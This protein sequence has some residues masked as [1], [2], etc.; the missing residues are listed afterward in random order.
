MS[1]SLPSGPLNDNSPR[2][3]PHPDSDHINDDTES[4]APDS[5]LRKARKRKLLGHSTKQRR[6]V[7]SRNRLSHVENG[8]QSSGATFSTNI[9]RLSA[10]VGTGG[11]LEE[12]KDLKYLEFDHQPGRRKQR[13]VA[14]PHG[15]LSEVERQSKGIGGQQVNAVSDEKTISGNAGGNSG[16]ESFGASEL[17][18]ETA[19]GGD[20]DSPTPVHGPV[21]AGTKRPY[22]PLQVHV[23]ADNGSPKRKMLR[24]R[25]DGKLSSPKADTKTEVSKLKMKRKLNKRTA[26]PLHKIVVMK[27]GQDPTRRHLI[28]LK[29][30]NVLAKSPS[31]LYKTPAMDTTTK[32]PASLTEPP[33]PT[34]P[35]F[36]GNS[37]FS[38]RGK[39]PED[40]RVSSLGTP[41][42]A[43]D[44]LAT[45]TA[46]SRK[47]PK[48]ISEADAAAWSRLAAGFSK[49][50]TMSGALMPPWPGGAMVHCRGSLDHAE[51]D[52]SITIRERPMPSS[53][54]KLKH[55]ET[56]IPEDE[57]ILFKYR[58][59]LSQVR[60]RLHDRAHSLHEQ[61]W[62]RKPERRLM[63]GSQVQETVLNRMSSTLPVT[64]AAAHAGALESV[65]KDT[66]T[67]DQASRKPRV[68][69]ALLQVFNDIASSLSPFDR[70]EC[71]MQD[72][73]HKYAPDCAANVLQPGQEA[74][75]LRDWLGGSKVV[76]VENGIIDREN[77]DAMMA[78]RRSRGRPRKKRKRAEE[79]DGF[80]LS[81]D[82]EGNEMDEITDPEDG[83]STNLYPF[84][85]KRTIMRA[86]D[87]RS[88]SQ[89]NG[90]TSRATNAVV[91]SGPHGCG[92]TAAVYAVAQ[93]L[94][95]EV[96]EINSGSRRS[97]KDL[98]DRVGD[99]TKNHL[100]H[101][102]AD[103]DD[104]NEVDEHL[105]IV[106]QELDSGRQSS[107]Q[108][109]LKPKARSKP[110]LK[111]RAASR[112]RLKNPSHQSPKKQK[113]QKQSLILL[114][115]VDVLF[116]ED[117][118]FWAT[119]VSLILQSKRPIIMTCTD[120][121]LLPLD[122]MVLHAI[123][124]FVAPPEPLAVD[125][126]LLLAGDEGHIL[127]RDAISTL[128]IS[129]HS[130]LRASISELNFWCRMA[131]GD[132]RG[133]LDWMLLGSSR[134]DC[135]N[136]EG[137]RLRVVS[138]GTYTSGMGFLDH[139]GECESSYNGLRGDTNLLSEALRWWNIDLE[140]W[141]ALYRTPRALSVTASEASLGSL[142][143]LEKF[144]LVTDAL[145]A[146]D[147]LP[148]LGFRL[149]NDVRRQATLPR[150]LT[151]KSRW[152][153]TAHNLSL[154]RRCGTTIL[155]ALLC[156]R[157]RHHRISLA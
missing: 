143:M 111:S 134:N 128:Y 126:L 103:S 49:P 56:Q 51:S 31:G 142:Q 139:D 80:I 91:I 18:A 62:L 25:N 133:G 72:W 45:V 53:R 20:T 102:A 48:T 82:D 92:K 155:M 65:D 147:V 42:S 149:N 151:D 109:F 78:P 88:I 94:D 16:T 113:Q 41:L 89:I 44:D 112:Q 130:D 47:K 93:E 12:Y 29:I 33:K 73:A 27:Y 97:G 34:H 77:R 153:L 123:F 110:V 1:A 75:R 60:E 5:K 104:L 107:L 15:L 138:D 52:R 131:I 14:S 135:S 23:S 13:R 10:P 83:P 101:Q 121:S 38:G 55:A 119:T 61:N 106:Q 74:M 40:P 81:T 120:E 17:Q 28:G 32:K 85:L 154:P 54:R 21:E 30:Q 59:Y 43:D 150:L 146:A 140:D 4:S 66:L 96:F 68:H 71:E 76:S 114:E 8:Y 24:L 58:Q 9:E 152:L 86:G 115:E 87:Q 124:R 70:F 37:G 129:N 118:Q 63:T 141:P 137:K 69:N 108:S 79:L 157:P 136:K 122:D 117:K 3:S 98:L 22:H 36:S 148:G 116:E 6:L 50:A 57:E 144:E 19:R 64:V 11:D 156:L 67:T 127:P 105:A 125:Y 35:F 2:P 90:I 7:L 26:S 84:A 132:T 145:S 99:M 100:V 46:S 39:P 95:F